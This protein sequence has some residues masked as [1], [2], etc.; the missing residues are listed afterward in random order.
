M[1]K[2]LLFISF[3][4]AFSALTFAQSNH[5]APAAV[6]KSPVLSELSG[7]INSTENSVA[8]G[9]RA[10]AETLNAELKNLYADYSTALSEQLGKT[11][12]AAETRELNQELRYAERRKAE[13]TTP[14]R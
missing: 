1:K 5:Q 4:T 13:L 12:S 8:K 7:K 9:S 3:C 6:K 11:T 2:Q 14:N 10:G